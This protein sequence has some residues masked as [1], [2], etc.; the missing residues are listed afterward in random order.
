MNRLVSAI[1]NTL[2]FQVYPTHLQ[3]VSGYTLLFYLEKYLSRPITKAT[4]YSKISGQKYIIH[5]TDDLIIRTT[6]MDNVFCTT[7]AANYEAHNSYDYFVEFE[8]ANIDNLN[9]YVYPPEVETMYNVDFESEKSEE[10]T[11]SD[12]NGYGCIIC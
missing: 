10:Q 6:D 2:T 8:F 9:T 11:T 1:D 3:N 4:I 7:I 12:S 5:L